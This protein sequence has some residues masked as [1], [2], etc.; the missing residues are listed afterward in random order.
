MFLLDFLFEKVHNFDLVN[1]R[2]VLYRNWR[3]FKRYVIYLGGG[4]E[5]SFCEAPYLK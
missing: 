1:D 4:E 5:V 2:L 3:A